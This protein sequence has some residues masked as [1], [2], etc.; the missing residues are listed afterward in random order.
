MK[1]LP[2]HV[3]CLS[4]C[5][6]LLLEKKC[7]F[8]PQTKKEQQNITHFYINPLALPKQHKLLAA[9]SEMS[10]SEYFGKNIQ[11]LAGESPKQNVHFSEE[12]SI[13]VSSVCF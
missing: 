5:L 6:L 9:L 8:G 1:F 13:K 2:S 3:V 11:L 7:D 10:I 12:L 4:K